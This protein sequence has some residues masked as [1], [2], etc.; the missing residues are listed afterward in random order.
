M[1]DLMPTRLHISDLSVEPYTYEE[2]FEGHALIITARVALSD[3]DGRR[4][5]DLIAGRNYYPVVREGVN[6]EVREMRFGQVPWSQH[7]DTT[8]YL[9]TLVERPFDDEG[10]QPSLGE[11][12]ASN[13]E[14]ALASCVGIVDALLDTLVTRGILT[15]EE[16]NEIRSKADTQTFEHRFGFSRVDD[17]DLW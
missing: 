14:R 3:E 13:V 7:G 9:L 15:G 12:Q 10:P 8:K 2:E 5:K 4:L 11:P 6:D 1:E 17:I 16:R